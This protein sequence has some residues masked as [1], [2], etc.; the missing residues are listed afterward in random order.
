ME[1]TVLSAVICWGANIRARGSKKLNKLME[2]CSELG[3]DVEHLELT[4]RKNV[5]R[6]AKHACLDLLRLLDL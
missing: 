6:K 2:T 5:T 4:G 1:G 3:T